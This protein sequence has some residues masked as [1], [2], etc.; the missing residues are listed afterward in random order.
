MYMRQ[1]SSQN[2]QN[3]VIIAAINPSLLV[4]DKFIIAGE[5]HKPIL[6]AM[7]YLRH[8]DDVAGAFLLLSHF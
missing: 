4:L 3:T 6:E 8:V 2:S 7:G 5:R 1:H